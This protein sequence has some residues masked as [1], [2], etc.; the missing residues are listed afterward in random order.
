MRCRVCGGLLERHV[1][2][3]PFKIGDRSIV[4]IK[5][6]PVLQ[7]HQCGET[8]LEHETMVRVDQILA[9][10]DASN[11]VQ[12]ESYGAEAAADH[13][14]ASPFPFELDNQSAVCGNMVAG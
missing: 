6:L 14:S 3:L 7:C 1:T 11:G 10:T 5:S 4:I 2:D 8:E 13:L 9:G 12:Y